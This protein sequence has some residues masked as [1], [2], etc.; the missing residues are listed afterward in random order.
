MKE[1]LVKALDGVSV[2]AKQIIDEP[3]AKA[4]A[5]GAIRIINCNWLIEKGRSGKGYAADEKLPRATKVVAH[6]ATSSAETLK[7][8]EDKR[9][10]IELLAKQCGVSTVCI[11]LDVGHRDDSILFPPEPPKLGVRQSAKPQSPPLRH[12]SSA[13]LENRR[14]RDDSARETL[15]SRPQRERGGSFRDITGSTGST[16]IEMSSIDA[17]PS[18]PSSPLASTTSLQP[19][20]PPS[21]PATEEVAP[22]VRLRRAL[23]ENGLDEIASVIIDDLKLRTIDQLRNVD[24]EELLDD[25]QG[26]GVSLKK[27]QLRAL[28]A[29][30]EEPPLRAKQSVLARDPGH[31]AHSSYYSPVQP[32]N[33]VQSEPPAS[34]MADPA[35]PARATSRTTAAL[36]TAPHVR[37]APT[38]PTQ[39]IPPADS[40]LATEPEP[41]PRGVSNL[42]S[43]SE[44]SA[45]P[46]QDTRL[47]S[48]TVT[49]NPNAALPPG[50]YVVTVEV[51]LS[52]FKETL[53]SR[54][55]LD[56]KAED[57]KNLLQ[58]ANS[59]EGALPRKLDSLN[60][61]LIKAGV[62][63][64]KAF[65]PNCQLLTELDKTAPA[66]SKPFLSPE[67]ASKIYNGLKRNS[68]PIELTRASCAP[69]ICL[70]SSLRHAGSGGR[71]GSSSPELLL[72]ARWRARSGRC[73]SRQDPRT[74]EG[75][76]R[77]RTEESCAREEG[78]GRRWPLR[79]RSMLT[80][81]LRTGERAVR[82][83]VA[84]RLLSSS[85]AQV[86]RRRCSRPSQN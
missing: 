1:G 24:F 59:C 25:L 72:A 48:M 34:A 67:D 16:A 27:H 41:P 17:A 78:T 64:G 54:E 81:D 5:D 31:P 45:E 35:P 53:L 39:P 3:I 30:I 70:S 56:D 20:P 68:K 50:A 2:E 44:S 69:A 23:D 61:Q 11:T 63:A 40:T 4:I 15:F 49:P 18:P 12:Q 84:L 8:V 36:S 83:C 65:L 10:L 79:G 37:V 82:R 66:R 42:I 73:S 80:T 22:H 19:S 47:E 6:F 51:H 13:E 76:A 77:H 58:S 14:E 26:E 75:S 74:I 7:N 38:S 85:T 9:T 28:R 60:M 46:V 29:F 71:I 52:T 43:Q 62:E 32:S 21:P 33:A 55:R 86:E 57:V